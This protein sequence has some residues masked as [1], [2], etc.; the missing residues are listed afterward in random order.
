MV[1]GSEIGGCPDPASSWGEQLQACCMQVYGHPAVR[2]LM[3]D[4]LHPGG[5]E[6]T[7]RLADWAS[8][9]ASARVLDAGSG[10]GASAVQLGEQ[11]GCQVLAVTL[12]EGVAA[13]RQRALQQGVDERVTFVQGDVLHMDLEPG[14]FDVVLMECV[15][16]ILPDKAVALRR[17]ASTL[18]PGG[19]L[20]LS[21]VT[22][23]GPIPVDIQGLL[24]VAGCVG[25]AR[26]LSEYSALV[27]EAGLKVSWCNSLPEVVAST[28]R[29][30]KSRL[31]LA[32]LAVKLG[33][34]PVAPS[35]V[36]R[37]RHLVEEV[38]RLVA[39]GTL[40]YAALVA[41]RPEPPISS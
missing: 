28:V 16:S 6:L 10:Q 14:A 33:Q 22:V 34:L 29:H 19:R 9:D 27:A 23:S 38:E 39:E 36:S 2:W 4:S 31:Q 25:D 32:Q 30:I 13:G 8:V 1:Q 17:L 12:E 41:T 15:L 3:G 40:G 5:E 18:K 35:L 11:R 21:D 20:A 26:S 7:S 24:A 37:A